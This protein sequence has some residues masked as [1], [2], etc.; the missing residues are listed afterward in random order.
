M[1]LVCVDVRTSLADLDLLCFCK[2]TWYVTT[3]LTRMRRAVWTAAYKY[4]TFCTDVLTRAILHQ[5]TGPQAV[6]KWRARGK[7]KVAVVNAPR[8]APSVHN[9]TVQTAP[10]LKYTHSTTRMGAFQRPTR[11][12]Q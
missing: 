10:R 7:R 12:R 5:T 2:N 4:C 9:C 1:V 6:K 11:Y 3:V 8:S